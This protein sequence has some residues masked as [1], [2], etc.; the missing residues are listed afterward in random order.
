MLCFHRSLCKIEKVLRSGVSCDDV[1]SLVFMEG[2]SGL[3]P[4]TQE[5]EVCSICLT[6]SGGSLPLE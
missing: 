6:S 1:Q 3:S 5:R 2:T 4:G